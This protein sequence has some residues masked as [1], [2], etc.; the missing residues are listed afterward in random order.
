VSNFSR[1]KIAICKMSFDNYRIDITDTREDNN[2]KPGVKSSIKTD[3][4]DIRVSKRDT[5]HLSA[6]MI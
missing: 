3:R 2:D 4:I 5:F 1:I 6:R